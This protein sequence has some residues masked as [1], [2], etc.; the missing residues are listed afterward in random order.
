MKMS[1]FHFETDQ[2]RV[3]DQLTTELQ[4]V[5][6]QLTFEFGPP[7]TPREFI[8]SAAGIQ[9]AFPAVISLTNAVPVLPK[10]QVIAFRPRRFPVSAIEFRDK[11]V[12]PRDVQ[13]TLLDNG[14]TAGLYLYIPSFQDDDIDFKQIGYLLLDEALGEYDVETKLGLIQ[15]LSPGAHTKGERYPLSEL[16]LLFDRL[17][18][19]LEGRSGRPS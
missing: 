5:D 15:M 12:D 13:F 7:K 18:A 14:T 9:S 4:K 19:R 2:E 6:P 16:P 3:F 17:V 11:R 10:W 8:I 1:Y